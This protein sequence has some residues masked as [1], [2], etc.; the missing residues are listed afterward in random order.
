MLEK[1]NIDRVFQENLKDLEIYPNHRVWKNISREMH[2]KPKVSPLTKWARIS[3]AASL[4][5]VAG[6]AAFFY[7]NQAP[8]SQF[9]LRPGNPA[10]ENSADNPVSN[11]QNAPNAAAQVQNIAQDN[12]GGTL[13]NDLTRKKLQ[14]IFVKQANNQVIV[15]NQDIS[16]LY[17]AS[18]DRYIVNK[19]ELLQELDEKQSIQER[20]ASIPGQNTERITYTEDATELAATDKKWSVGPNVAPVFYNSLQDGSPVSDE[21]TNNDINSESSLSVGVR[22]NYQLN[23][24]FYIQSGINRVDL[25]YTTPDVSAFATSSKAG[26]GNTNTS[27]K[28]YYVVPSNRGG[29]NSQS[30]FSKTG[31]NGDLN[32]SIQYIELPVEMKYNLMDKKF[33]LN[34]VGGF[35]TLYLSDNS[36]SLVSSDEITNLGNADNLN[37]FNFSGNFGVDFDYKIS[38]SWYLNVAPMV[39]YQF[40][41][42]SNSSGNF[43]PYYFGLYSGLNYKF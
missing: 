9:Q 20:M 38:N 7:F 41:T 24:K 12:N 13:D 4:V 30:N 2:G 34:L 28:E 19:D 43:R 11:P 23:K 35:S 6:L 25:A 33:G 22:V 1:K 32:Q 40:N 42:Y 16:K 31:I 36:V 5:L 27:R 8:V 3:S 18:D 39:K 15:T 14:P 10:I 26:L 37:T 21:L 29:S 17:V